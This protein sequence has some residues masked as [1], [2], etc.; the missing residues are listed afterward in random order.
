MGLMRA[1]LQHKMWG[2]LDISHVFHYISTLHQPIFKKIG[3][4]IEDFL[5]L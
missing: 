4:Q 5:M 2:K 1:F 3:D